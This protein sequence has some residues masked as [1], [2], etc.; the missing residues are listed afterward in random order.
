MEPAAHFHHYYPFL[1][2]ECRG[3]LLGHEQITSTM[4]PAQML[5][6]AG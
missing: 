5:L 6:I 4:A 2:E 1:A 3:V